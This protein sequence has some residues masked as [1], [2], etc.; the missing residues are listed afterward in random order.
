[1]S[2]ASIGGDTAAGA[3]IGGPYGALAGAGVGILSSLLGSS[4]AEQ[5]TQ[6]QLQAQLQAEQQMQG[7]NAQTLQTIQGLYSPY[8][9]VGQTGLSGLQSGNFQAAQTPYQAQTNVASYL[10]PSLQFQ[11]N[12]AQRSSEQGAAASGGLYSGAQA[13][14]L[15]T[16][17]QGI[18]QTGYNNA[19]TQMQQANNLNL[20]SWENTFNQNLAN[21]NQNFKQYSTLAAIGQNAVGNTANAAYNMNQNTNQ[22]IGQQGATQGGINAAPYQLAANQWGAASNLA[23]SLPSAYATAQTAQSQQ[24]LNSAEANYYNNLNSTL[25]Y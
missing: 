24:G 7:N 2:I 12:A 14:A 10:D 13:K 20:N 25:G 22:I 19:F 11:E 16:Q 3:S 17:E 6:A 1:M 8:T 23:T 9:S 5:S 15:Q 4:D 18:G 21:A